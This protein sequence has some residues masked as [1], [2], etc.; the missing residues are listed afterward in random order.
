MKISMAIVFSALIM[1]SG[2]AYSQN[3]I[4]VNAPVKYSN[5]KPNNIS[6]SYSKIYY[7]SSGGRITGD[8]G[9][10][11]LDS[12]KSIEFLY[13]RSAST[14][15]VLSISGDIFTLGPANGIYSITIPYD[16]DTTNKKL[17]AKQGGRAIQFCDSLDCSSAEYEI[18]L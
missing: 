8:L 6:N 12:S 7:I 1:F 18:S 2:I 4:R 13:S 10:N 14:N 5:K 16:K 15:I 9:I 3:I 17:T 11:Y